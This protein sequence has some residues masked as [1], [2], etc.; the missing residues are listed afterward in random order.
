MLQRINEPDAFDVD[1]QPPADDR[2]WFHFT[3]KMMHDR[4]MVLFFRMEDGWRRSMVFLNGQA[5]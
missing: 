1:L 2:L 5:S 3:V 4:A